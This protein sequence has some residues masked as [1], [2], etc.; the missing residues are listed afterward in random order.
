[1]SRPPISRPTI[2]RANMPRAPIAPAR[3]AAFRVLSALDRDPRQHSDDLLRAPDIDRLPAVDRRLA[4]ALTLGV[5][6][7]QLLLDRRLAPLLT[8]QAKLDRAVSIALRLGAFQLLFLERIPARAAIHDSVELTKQAGHHFASRMVNAVLR[9]LAPEPS[10]PEPSHPEPPPDPAEAQ[11]PWLLARW[12]AA[13]GPDAAAAISR[14]N[15]QIPPLTLRLPDPR[16]ELELA[17]AGLTLAPGAILTHAR[18]LLTGDGALLP[19]N[20]VRIQ[21]EGS[22]LIAELA[23]E[24][25]RILDC[26]AAPGGKTAILAERNPA[27]EIL[28]CDISPPRL[29]AMQQFLAA[30]PAT[31]RVRTALADA[32]RL[33]DAPEAA[34]LFDLVLCDAPCSGTG[35]L[36]RNPEIKLHLEPQDLARQQSRQ[37][38]ILHSALGKLAPGG[39]LLYSTCSLEPEEN[40]AVVRRSLEQHPGT[41]LLPIEKKIDTLSAQGAL[42]ENGAPLRN[43]ALH[44]DFL[45]TLPGLLPCDGF[46][47]ALITRD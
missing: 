34:G 35:T 46:F 12:Q 26:C 2:S 38:A 37:L 15:Q 36:A 32:T 33:E 27:A 17:A 23:G 4:T 20:L 18:T 22:Q 40:E 19:P 21:D 10:H 6:R 30:R 29:R 41:R 43:T 25:K 7:W 1:M 13:F 16:T 39:R 31:A 5:L 3:L 28:A 11:P 42:A 44:G 47:A 8:R 24:G 14:F 45:R 9:R